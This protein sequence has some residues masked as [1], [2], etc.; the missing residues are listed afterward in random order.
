VRYSLESEVPDGRSAAL[1]AQFEDLSD[2]ELMAL[3][4]S[5]DADA[6]GFLVNRMKT[7][8]SRVAYAKI[9]DRQ[10]ANDALQEARITIFNTAK[11]FRGESKVW[12]WVYRVVVNSCI[13]Q[14]RREKTRSFLNTTDEAL[15][16]M[17]QSDFSDRIDS[18]IVIRNALDQLPND[19]RE[20]VSL[21]YIEGYGVEEAS[22]ILDIPTG[23]I[24]SRCARGKSALAVILKDL[25]PKLEPDSSSNRLTSGG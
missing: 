22:K 4:Q 19:Q 16:S 6:L 12:T 17:H 23:T 20:A 1:S 9:L 5:G 21:V 8:M 3:Y 2:E 14:L 25:R 13:D 7:K 15:A 18:E 10:L 24:K 11:S